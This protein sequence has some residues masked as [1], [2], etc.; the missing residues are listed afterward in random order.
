M[1]DRELQRELL[2]NMAEHYPRAWDFRDYLKNVPESDEQKLAANLQYLDEHGLAQSGLRIGL[3]GHLSFSLPQITAQGMDFLQDDGGLAAILGVVTIRL[4]DDTIKS[5]VEAKIRESDLPQTEKSR[6]ASA[7]RALP[8]EVTK[9]LT[10][11]LV[12][13]GLAQSHVAL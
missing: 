1:L 9:H 2:T 3:D 6:L 11:K 7:V 5:L 10:L 12:D 4:H 13:I 8:A